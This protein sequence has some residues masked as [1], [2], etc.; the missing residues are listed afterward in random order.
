MFARSCAYHI[1]QMSHPLNQQMTGQ[2]LWVLKIAP[3]SFIWVP[4]ANSFAG[5][6]NLPLHIRV[7]LINKRSQK[8]ATLWWRSDALGRFK[9]ANLWRF[10]E[11]S[12]YTHP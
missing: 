11:I 10:S 9:L 8:A 3:V 6:Q 1:N 5:E 4:F 2:K 7:S 12:P